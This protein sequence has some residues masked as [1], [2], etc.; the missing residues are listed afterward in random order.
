MK[1]YVRIELINSDL[2][3]ARDVMANVVDY[4]L[5]VSEFELYSR[6]Y[7]YFWT[8]ALG[9]GMNPLISP[10]KGYQPQR[11]MCH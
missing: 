10:V 9:K 3:F 11:L 5:E 8:I 4:G 1:H 2:G 7:I 6:C